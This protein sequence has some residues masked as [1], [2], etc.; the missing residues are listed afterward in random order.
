MREYAPLSFAL[1]SLADITGHLDGK[2]FEEISH[3]LG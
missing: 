3:V 2:F 1:G